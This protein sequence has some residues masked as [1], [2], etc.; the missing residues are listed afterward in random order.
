MI[1]L[2]AKLKQFNFYHLQHSDAENKTLLSSMKAL[3]QIILTEHERLCLSRNKQIGF[4]SSTEHFKKLNV[5]INDNLKLLDKNRVM[6]WLLRSIEKIESAL[7]A[8]YNLKIVVLK[9]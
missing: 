5:Q 1:Q 4:E 7:G 8:S 3:N 9:S 2:G 6:R